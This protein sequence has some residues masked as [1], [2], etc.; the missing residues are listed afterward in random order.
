MTSRERILC[1]IELGTPDRVPVTPWGLGRLDKDGPMAQR[2]IKETDPFIGAG[3]GGAGYF[4]GAAACS[5]SETQEDR[6]ITVIET[7]MGELRSVRRRTSITSAQVEFP[8]KTGDDVE[9][10]LS[11]PYEPPEV[12]ATPFLERKDEIGEDGLVLCGMPNPGMIPAVYFSPEDYA[13]L[14]IEDRDAFVHLVEVATERCLSW[15]EEA[16]RMEVDGFRVIGG[17]YASTQLGPEAFDLT[18]RDP[19]KKLADMMHEHGAVC[20]YHNHGPMN[21][22]LESIAEIGIDALDPLEAPPWGD[23]ELADAKRRVGDKFCLVGNLDDMEVIEKLDGGTIEEM[24]EELIEAAG[25][26]GFCL[27]GTASGTFTEP[28]AE[29]FIRMVEVSK[30]MSG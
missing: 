24:A 21:A 30:R 7:P 13:L 27:G 25:P 9:K 15:L 5:R 10:L 2:L 12:D 29:N 18:M 6:T 4:L 20:Y 1:A 3:V 23:C 16:C 8:C 14:W 26:G 17:E 28:A 11:I 19:D 22:F